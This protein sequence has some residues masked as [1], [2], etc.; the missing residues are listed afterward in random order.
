[1]NDKMQCDHI[2]HTTYHNIQEMGMQ[3]ES[4]KKLY[5][6]YSILNY[7]CEGNSKEDLAL[8]VLERMS[9]KEV[10]ELIKEVKENE[11]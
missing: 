1:M 4:I 2:G 9:K 5:D 10:A 7:L 11:V 8:T 6:I 3:L